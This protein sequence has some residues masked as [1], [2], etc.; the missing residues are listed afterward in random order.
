MATPRRSR[1][2]AVLALAVL[3]VATLLFG[4]GAVLAAEPE[5]G[6]AHAVLGFVEQRF[7]YQNE[8]RYDIH[9]FLGKVL[10]ICPCT[11]DLSREQYRKASFHAD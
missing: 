11:A 1:P 3:L 10:S 9:R 4:G 7:G 8:L 2:L 6:P 5:S